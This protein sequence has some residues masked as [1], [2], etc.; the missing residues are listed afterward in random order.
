MAEWGG[1]GN[2]PIRNSSMWRHVVHRVNNSLGS[3]EKK[4]ALVLVSHSLRRVGLRLRLGVNDTCGG[5]P[6]MRCSF[7]SS[8]VGS[9]G[10]VGGSARDPPPPSEDP[11]G[12]GSSTSFVEQ[13]ATV[14]D[15]HRKLDAHM[16]EG[17]PSSQQTPLTAQDITKSTPDPKGD[18]FTS[19]T[20]LFEV[21]SSNTYIE[22][23][24]QNGFVINGVECRGPVA[25]FRTVFAL[26]NTTSK[27]GPL[28]ASASDLDF[29]KLIHPSPEIVILGTG[30]TIRHAAVDTE[31]RKFV[32]DTLR[33]RMEILDTPN[34]INYFNVLAA[35][36]RSAVAL[37]APWR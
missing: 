28:Q 3:S 16:T 2:F 36:N 18:I 33:A 17:H 11:R 12:L 27:D 19:K 15:E 24:G 7:S 6:V 30:K 29:L 13:D 34:A 10:G 22:S 21:D 32:K 31:A 4:S 20:Q 37:L 5:F 9:G 8:V 14:A 25:C 23:Y 26:W 35:E 1:V